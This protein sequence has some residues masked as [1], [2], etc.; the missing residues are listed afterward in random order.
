MI[1]NIIIVLLLGS[2]VENPAIYDGEFD[3]DYLILTGDEVVA[4][5]K[6]EEDRD[7]FFDKI[8]FDD[9]ENHYK[10]GKQ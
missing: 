6:R 9:W 3:F 4:T 5:F 2:C 8:T 7:F 1:L 10:K